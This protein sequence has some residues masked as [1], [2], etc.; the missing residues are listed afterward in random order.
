MVTANE[1][2]CITCT[3]P[4]DQSATCS[5]NGPIAACHV[6]MYSYAIPPGPT[7][8]TSGPI[9]MR[10]IP[11]EMANPFTYITTICTIC[12]YSKGLTPPGLGPTLCGC[13]NILVVGLKGYI[14]RHAP[15]KVGPPEK[16]LGC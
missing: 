10:L 9:V 15:M 5:R 2:P 14:R 16:P 1:S 8:V 3:F 7:K 13:I 6:R 12:V 11:D 4:V